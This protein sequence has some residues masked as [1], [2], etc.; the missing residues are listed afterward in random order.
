FVDKFRAT[1]FEGRFYGSNV[2]GS[3]ARGNPE[4]IE[5][6]LRA[7]E[8]WSIDAAWP[9]ACALHQMRDAARSYE[10]TVPV[11]LRLTALPEAQRRAAA[12]LA[13]GG[14]AGGIDVAVDRLLELTHDTYE[15]DRIYKGHIVA[16]VAMTALG[17][18][19]RQ[20]DRVVPRILDMFDSF[21]E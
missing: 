9:A 3:L 18:I 1:E 5:L 20:A 14:V 16:G 12:A 6:L 8:T 10:Q 19:G 21:E 7:M 17:E 15:V 4:V 2:L 11:L 13:L